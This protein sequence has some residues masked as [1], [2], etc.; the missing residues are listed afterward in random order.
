ME[1]QRQTTVTA[2]FSGTE[3]LFFTSINTAKATGIYH[4]Y[5]DDHTLETKPYVSK[6]GTLAQYWFNINDPPS[7]TLTQH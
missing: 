2:Y 6:H 3:L 1:H 7:T 4:G 5:I